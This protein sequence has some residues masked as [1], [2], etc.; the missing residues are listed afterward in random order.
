MDD[1]IGIT[2]CPW[3]GLTPTFVDKAMLDSC[4]SRVSKHLDQHTQTFVERNHEFNHHGKSH[5]LT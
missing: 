3:L 5:M 1:Q 4:H 2:D